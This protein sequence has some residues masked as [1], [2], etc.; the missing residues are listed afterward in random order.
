MIFAAVWLTL[1]WHLSTSLSLTPAPSLP[2]RMVQ[3]VGWHLK[4]SC[5]P[6]PTRIPNV[7]SETNAPEI[8]THLHA[9]FS[10]FANW[11]ACISFDSRL[12]KIFT[13]KSPFSEYKQ[14]VRV[15]T[16]VLGGRRPAR[17]PGVF[18]DE[19]WSLIEVCW[20]GNPSFRPAM[21]DVTTTINSW[22]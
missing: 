9:P 13:R 12:S 22:K 5:P 16:E 8:F 3:S 6:A 4:P 18:S 20:Q 2:R 15:A 19:M 10:R 14:D 11:L 7:L 21:S 17:P 1:D